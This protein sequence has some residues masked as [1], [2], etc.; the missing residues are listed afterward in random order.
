MFCLSVHQIFFNIV[1]FSLQVLRSGN[2]VSW[3]FFSPNGP[4]LD[5]IRSLCLSGMVCNS[6][7]ILHPWKLVS[8]FHLIT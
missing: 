2:L 8:Y 7:L 1:F 4:A 5:H 3:G 6:Y